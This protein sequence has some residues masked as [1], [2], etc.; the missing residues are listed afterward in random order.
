VRALEDQAWVRRAAA[1]EALCQAGPHE[2]RQLVRKL[3]GDPEPRVRLRVALALLDA[4]DRQAVPA[5]IALLGELPLEQG[6]L[7]EAA[8]RTLATDK[9]PAVALGPDEGSRL[10]CR[11]AWD[12][13]WREHGHTVDL[14]RLDSAQRLLGYTLVVE[15]YNQVRRSGRV[16]ELDNA[17]K[18]RWEILGLQ[19]PFDAQIVPG[20]RLL[21]VEQG[22]SRVTE[23]DFKGNILWQRPLNLPLSAQRLPNGNTFLVGRSQLLELDRNGKEVFNQPR[24]NN[25]IMAAQK[26]PDGHI[27][28]LTYTWMYYR[29][30][31]QGKQVKH[32]RLGPFS[33]HSNLVQFLPGDRVL[34]PEHNANRVVEFNAEGQRVWEASVPTPTG[35]LRLPN[36]NT[37]VASAAGQR[38]V[39][40]NRAG[41]VV[42]EHKDTFNPWRARRR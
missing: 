35:V 9:S 38:L 23:R 7:A 20:E 15:Q 26:L 12:A 1:A 14:V 30:D 17:G 33:Y 41:K 5:V 34:V 18:V 3:L 40:L 31:A 36:G 11:D 37:L 29:L 19:T 28:Y 42:W 16:F 39:E 32:F 2:Q 24:P 4:G 22:L 21:L 25:D 13:W 10:K 27:A 6:L 8:L